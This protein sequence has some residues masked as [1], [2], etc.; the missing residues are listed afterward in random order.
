MV[1]MFE[2]VGER[3]LGIVREKSRD[4]EHNEAHACVMATGRVDTSIA[5]APRVRAMRHV[6]ED[7]ELAHPAHRLDAEVGQARSG[8]L[9]A[10]VADEVPGVVRELH[11]ADADLVEQLETTEIVAEG[12]G[13][14][15]A[16]MAPRLRS[17]CARRRSAAVVTLITCSRQASKTWVQLAR[18]RIAFSY[19]NGRSPTT[20]TV[21]QMT[22]TPA[23][24]PRVPVLLRLS[25]G[26]AR[27]RLVRTSR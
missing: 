7:A 22:S 1:E 16:R 26:P 17:S 24:L 8:A 27:S 10:R 3:G 12:R 19:E 2:P 15:N 21:T 14:W 23:F 9:D 25:G 5:R 4:D 18:S 6:D 11:D 13:V 20:P